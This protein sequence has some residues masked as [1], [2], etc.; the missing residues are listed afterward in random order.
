MMPSSKRADSVKAPRS[1][2]PSHSHHITFLIYCRTCT[3]TVQAD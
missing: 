3:V 2:N 1:D